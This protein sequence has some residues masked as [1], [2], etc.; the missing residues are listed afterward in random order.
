MLAIDW[1][2]L[3]DVGSIIRLPMS[4]SISQFLRVPGKPSRPRRDESKEIIALF[5]YDLRRIQTP[6]FV[7]DVLEREGFERLPALLKLTRP[8]PVPTQ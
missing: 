2:T 1:S 4:S 3:A 6:Q 5:E 8:L 7:V